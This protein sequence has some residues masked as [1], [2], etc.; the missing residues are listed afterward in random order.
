[1][2]APQN[3]DDNVPQQGIPN[4]EIGT[5]L[6]RRSLMHSRDGPPTSLDD[7]IEDHAA[8]STQDSAITRSAIRGCR[9]RRD[10]KSTRRPKMAD[11]HRQKVLDLPTKSLPWRQDVRDVN[12]A[13][14][15][16]LP[17]A[18]EPNTANSAMPGGLA[19]ISQWE[20]NRATAVLSGN[21]PRHTQNGYIFGRMEPCRQAEP[22]LRTG[23]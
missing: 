19:A 1:M 7:L 15:G 4:V 8:H 3:D 16:G 2:G 21:T 13:S 12:V 17:R 14:A 11:T 10:T 23:P 20:A 9:A 22:Q 5:K 6:V 18:T